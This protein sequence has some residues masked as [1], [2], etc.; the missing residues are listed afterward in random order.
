MITRATGYD[1]RVVAADPVAVNSQSI[2][3]ITVDFPFYCRWQW[4]PPPIYAAA[5]SV[6]VCVVLVLIDIRRLSRLVYSHHA[7]EVAS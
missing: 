6:C 3:P 4:Y 1:S 7:S 2:A 5:I